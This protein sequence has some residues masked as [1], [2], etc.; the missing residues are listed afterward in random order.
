MLSRKELADVWN[1]AVGDFL[2]GGPVAP[3]EMSAWFG[4][5]RGSGRTAVSTDC[6]AEPYIGDIVGEFRAVILGLNPGRPYP[7]LQGRTG[8]YAQSI[9][10]V[11]SYQTWAAGWPYLGRAWT[12]AMG[13]P[14][15]FHKARHDW[16]RRWIG[17]PLPASRTHLVIELYPWHS[18]NLPRPFRP[19][20]DAVRRYVWEPLSELGPVPVFAFGSRALFDVLPAL[21]GVE[22]LARVP[23][24]GENAW[25]YGFSAPTREVMIGR[26]PTGGLLY[27]ANHD[28]SDNPPPLSE[29]AVHKRLAHTY[30]PG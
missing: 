27:V 4:S 18:I 15:R 22:V 17:E 25:Q 29:I 5:C 13:R 11:G 23:G 16:V 7:E 20:T 9:R 8:R 26:V 2:N 21:P 1:H 24:P 28:G 3:V 30:A 14:N 12:D 10:A 6:F 19:D